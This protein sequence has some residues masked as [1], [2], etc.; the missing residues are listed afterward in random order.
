MPQAAARYTGYAEGG[1]LVMEQAQHV[2]T[3]TYGFAGARA[4][5]ADADLTFR[6][7][8]A[9]DIWDVRSIAGSQYNSGLLDLI[10]YHRTN[11]P[12]LMTGTGR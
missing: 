11:F 4:L 7:V 1:A 10:R 9:K 8:L 6:Q 3:R 2:L 12:G 5:K